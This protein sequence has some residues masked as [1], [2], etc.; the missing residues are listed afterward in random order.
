MINGKIVLIRY[1][2]SFTSRLIQARPPIQDY[3]TVVKNYLLSF[4]GVKDRLSWNFESFSKGRVPCAKLNVKGKTLFVYLALDPEQYVEKEG[5]Y[6]F[7]NVG[8][9]PK[10]A[11]TP[12]LMRVKSDRGLK[13]TLELIDEIMKGLG[14]PQREIPTVDYHYPYE[15]TDDLVE[16]DL[17]KVIYPAGTVIDENTDIRRVNISDLIS[18]GI[19]KPE[20]AAPAEEKPAEEPVAEEEPVEEPAEEPVVEEAPIE[21]P[22]E[23]PVAEE[24][25]V[26]EPAEEPVAEEE[27]VEGIVL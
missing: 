26:E 25:P 5:K 18:L 11:K 2:H 23:E 1:R 8:D 21:E 20:D 27:P 14:I 17:V 15:Q 19:L 10:F 3:Y 16:R 24:E 13:Y 7:K 22:A 4:K 6:R 12:F 9:K